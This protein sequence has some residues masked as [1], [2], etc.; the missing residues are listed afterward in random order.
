MARP[1]RF[2][3]FPHGPPGGRCWGWA[4]GRRE[5][6]GAG[7]DEW[8]EE[9]QRQATAIAAPAPL[10]AR[11]AS[12]DARWPLRPPPHYALT[13]FFFIAFT[14]F[15]FCVSSPHVGPLSP[16]RV[17][18]FTEFFF[19]GFQAPFWL[20]RACHASLPSF[21][22]SVQIDTTSIVTEFS[23]PLYLVLPSFTEF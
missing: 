12:D 10:F 19:T 16:R 23:D 13:G 22:N 18:S 14:E 1:Y 8:R 21:A 7:V 20:L 11:P 3:P 5:G 17:P 4:G 2:A 9:A 6:R 15:F